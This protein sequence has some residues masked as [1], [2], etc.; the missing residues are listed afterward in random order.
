M[1]I[2]I[3]LFLLPLL[4]L[5]AGQMLVLLFKFQQE[6]ASSAP[7]DL[8]SCHKTM[9]HLQASASLD[10]NSATSSSSYLAAE[11]EILLSCLEKII[12][13]VS[14]EE[15]HSHETNLEYC[16]AVPSTGGASTCWNKS[17]GGT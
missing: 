7:D 15:L 12:H 4:M 1:S 9:A 17:T 16:S 6:L 3:F 11:S 10:R 14:G 8:Q 5:L 2:H 13:R